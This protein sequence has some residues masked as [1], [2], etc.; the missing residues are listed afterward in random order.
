[1][2]LLLRLKVLRGQELSGE[3]TNSLEL[4]WMRHTA[5]FVV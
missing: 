5:T 1:V 4:R 3:V 2:I